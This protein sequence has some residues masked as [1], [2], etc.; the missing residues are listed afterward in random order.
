L[1]SVPE[2]LI[3]PELVL[4][5]C[6]SLVSVA[7]FVRVP[8]LINELPWLWTMPLFVIV[9]LLLRYPSFEK[10]PV[11]LLNIT[12]PGL[13][14]IVALMEKPPFSIKP[15]LLIVP[16][17][18]NGTWLLKVPKLVSTPPELISI[19]PVLFIST[20]NPCGIVTVIPFGI[21]TCEVGLGIIPPVHVA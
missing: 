11:T 14:L 4:L 17:L 16:V 2:L 1:V 15:L 8:E 12:P 6:S 18:F 9:L 13:L 21:I 3:V 7:V 10:V 20:V 5:R 19:F